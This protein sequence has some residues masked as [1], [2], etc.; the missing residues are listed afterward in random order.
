[1][2]KEKADR[3]IRI[4]MYLFIAAV[5]A[6]VCYA[7][8]SFSK[9]Y[10]K[11]GFYDDGKTMNWSEDWSYSDSDGLRKR[12]D[13]PSRN[14]GNSDVDY[15]TLSKALPSSIEPGWYLAYY[16][17]FQ[18]IEV[19]VDDRLVDKYEG[20]KSLFATRIP[21]NEQ[22]FIKLRSEYAGKT[23][24]LKIES[25]LSNYKKS[26]NKVCIG[27][28]SAI[29]YS[30][31]FNSIFTVVSGIVITI[32]GVI[33]FTT[34]IVSPRHIGDENIYVYTGSTMVILG[35]WFTIQACV[36]QIVFDDMAASHFI[37]LITLLILSIPILRYVDFTLNHRFQTITDII[38]VIYLGVIFFSLF[39]CL[40]L[41]H[42]LME[43]LI[44]NHVMIVFS[45]L[46]VTCTFWRV[47][48]GDRELM[49]RLKWIE[50]SFGCLCIGCIVE[51]VQFYLQPAKETGVSL[52]V[53]AI[54]YGFCTFMWALESN[55]SETIRQESARQQS[56][57]KSMF[58]A[59]MSHE[60]RTPINA[61][62]GMDSLIIRKTRQPEV[63]GYA[64]NLQESGRKLLALINNIL[65]FSR[66]ESGKITVDIEKTDMRQLILRVSHFASI[67][68]KDV[69]VSFTMENDPKMPSEL[70]V[71]SDKIEK[72]VDNLIENALRYTDKG[73][74]KV[75]WDIEKEKRKNECALIIKVSDTG[76]GIKPEY[77]QYIFDPFHRTQK[78]EGAGLGLAIS[79]RLA[80]MMSGSVDVSSVEG[81][82]TIFTVRIPARSE[83]EKPV[84][85]VNAEKYEE[86]Q[87]KGFTALRARILVVDDEPMNLK[88]I[89]GMLR[90]TR[91]YI[92]T[93]SNG[94]QALEKIG[95][96]RYQIIF[97]DYLMPG[98]N[99]I[100]LFKR[101]K[102]ITGETENL[103]K[104]TPV[105]MMTADNTP[106]IKELVFLNGFAGY[107]GKPVTEEEIKS[108][109]LKYLPHD[110][111]CETS[112][113][114]R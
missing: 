23:I 30:S 39:N 33:L 74:V 68:P 18:K 28:K 62:L 11:Q 77:L 1:M 70:Q 104:D 5:A 113:G 102:A 112:K 98:M 114:G 64:E 65:E 19:Y 8:V 86:E 26:L 83:S 50:I 85:I 90:D 107:L 38:C 45:V 7:I 81:S 54:A 72:I 73:N 103:N 40:V 55:Q 59:N 109:I 69:H 34:R 22:R 12:I 88:V 9:P 58:L 95:S 57:A 25:R 46:F 78:A 3:I 10:L 82:G 24:S 41:K 84:G 87:L 20:G 101:M 89:S 27:Q 100:E 42:D 76:K 48:F 49:K 13:L 99:G 15:L 92:D 61:I 6:I 47:V 14:R 4:N 106:E 97:L 52:A 32:F 93:V 60:I 36:S 80:S 35:M 108:T 66:I 79:R 111:V 21:A 105:I 53:S 91:I 96:G 16:S 71:D 63:K 2:K 17:S 56:I 51:V 29:L 43:T 44:L 94:E 31:L 75:R 37:E 110:M 67:C